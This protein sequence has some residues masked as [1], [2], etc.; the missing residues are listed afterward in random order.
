MAAA[1]RRAAALFAAAVLLAAALPGRPQAAPSSPAAPALG[2]PTIPPL[3]LG[4]PAARSLAAGESCSYAAALAAGRPYLLAVEQRGIDVAV[5]VRGAD[6]RRLAAA[7][8]PLERWGTELLLLR[9]AADGL[10]RID[11]RSTARGVGAGRFAARLDEL[12]ETTAAERERAA[13]LAAATRGAE[14]LAPPAAAGAAE[15]ALA[16]YREALAHFHAAADLPGEAEAT[17]AVAALAR[18][19]GARREAADLYR[20]AAERWHELGRPGREIRAWND[21]G[22]TLWE[23]GDL[24]AADEALARGLALAGAAGD[25]YDEADLGNDACIIVHARGEI[26]AALACYREAAERFRRLGEARDE[27]AVENNLGFAAYQLGE[28]EPAEASYRRAL[29]IRRATGDRAGEAQTL[30]NLAVL[31]RSLG[32]I[33]TALAFYGEEQAILAGL[34]DRRQEASV[35]NNLGVAYEALGEPE[36]ARLD[37]TRALALRRAAADRPGEIITLD[38]LGWLAERGGDLA[39]AAA[40]YR[41]ALS[42]A[43]TTADRRAQAA[44]LGYLGAA[45]TARGSFATGMQELDRALALARDIGDQ[46]TERL[47]LLRQGE[48]IAARGRPAAALR[49]LDRALEITRALGDRAGE[50][51]IATARARAGRDAGRLDAARADAAAAV[52][53]VEALRARLGDPDLRASFLG[54]RQEAYET[55]VD[56]LMRLAAARP[57][58]GFERAALEASE[59]GRARTLLDFLHAN[60]AE[61]RAIDPALAARRRDLDRRL[62]LKTDRLQA[63]LARGRGAAAQASA[64]AL[65]VEAVRSEL[66]G[67]DA[68]I[69]RR[70]PRY[71]ELTRPAN[72]T[73]AE[74]QALLDPGTLLLE[75]ALGRERSYLWAVGATSLRSFVLPGRAAIERAAVALQRA[76]RS[77]PDAGRTGAAGRAGLGRELAHLLLAPVAG[78][79]GDRRLA[80]VA[81]GALAYIPFDVLPEPAGTGG[82]PGAPLLRRHEVIALPSA[83]AL[84]VERRDLAHRTPA[85]RLALVF[86]DPVFD[87]D[88]S[89]VAARR[90]AALA[91]PATPAETAGEAERPPRYARLRFSRQEAL[92]IAALAPAG[93]VDTALD[94]A[95]DRDLALSGNLHAYRYLHFATHGDFDA[96]HPELSALVLSRV[97][98][99]GEPRDGYLRP[100]DIDAL[101][102]D[103]DLVVLSGCGTALGR[104]V[105]GEGLLGLTRAFLDAGAARVV[106]SLW[107]VDDRATGELMARFYRG[108]WAE[109]RRPAEALRRARLSLAAERR[110]RDPF[111][112]G[113]FVL[114]GD[115]R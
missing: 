68:E 108:L 80:I 15:R 34:D 4:S 76:L 59:R 14:I 63:L 113:A 10:Y 8:G 53:A 21:L 67:L 105:R 93:A 75:V 77:P 71:A 11:I 112:W 28:P 36:R 87:R 47:V 56:V 66:D 52:A 98:A 18:R 104:E 79:L 86:G 101:D 111:Y 107:A 95:A 38:N 57:Q 2:A 103:A 106:A 37:D 61:P 17:T 89:R 110:F 30:N 90:P 22:M 102:L 25:A 88:D 84:A 97:D 27:A 3:A 72:A 81:D 51:T 35:L 54:S 94:F 6:G 20:D 26:R 114:Q 5:D 24:A 65:D 69:G 91:T 92:A 33:G 85:P 19:A 50:A 41:Q 44:A 109:R 42:I 13:A 16:A 78:E 7:D 43:E 64:L 55:Q 83:G 9:P 48:A 70:D 115:W 82:E 40:F 99:A 49:L 1:G 74:I 100:R 31:Y 73:C 62:A 60:G 29:A 46:R 45:D 39:G 58:E 32:E 23:M 96:A 12:A